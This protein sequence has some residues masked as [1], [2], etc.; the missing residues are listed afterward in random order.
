[1]NKR[2]FYLDNLSGLLIIEMIFLCHI[3]I[4][5]VMIP[6]SGFLYQLQSFLIF[7][8]PWF[9]FK[10]GMFYGRNLK[11][12][13]TKDAKK[14]L[15]PFVY[16]SFFAYSM[17]IVCMLLRHETITT[18]S[19]LWS[20]LEG[21]VNGAGIPWNQP[22]WFLVTLF[23]VKA[24]YGYI[25]KYINKYLILL[26]SLIIAS[27]FNGQSM[28]LDFWIGT[29][30][31]ALFFYCLGDLLRDRQY[32]KN[33]WL[34][35]IVVYVLRYCFTWINDWDARLNKIGNEDSYFLV[36]LV[37]LCGI[38]L[39]N[40]LFKYCLDRKI[41]LLTFTGQHSMIFY[42][43]HFPF[44]MIL[45]FY[46]VPYL[47]LEGTISG[48]IICSILMVIYL[49]FVYIGLLMLHKVRIKLLSKAAL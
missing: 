13:I 42:A 45:R 46:V 12:D 7:F 17:Q 6:D 3:R 35:A 25:E 47:K 37:L 38:I 4:L 33:I 23:I 20:Q 43:S 5:S 11:H 1:M 9:F 29:S 41:P 28:V 30:F 44:I 8:M 32:K 16:Y 22:M 34:L 48:F 26:L 21:I 19:L 15:L 36:I 2:V 14:L 10:S 24:T 39:F 18:D 49:A 27:V 31:Q 40:N